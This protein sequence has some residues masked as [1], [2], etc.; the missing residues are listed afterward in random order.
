M[1]TTFHAS[2]LTN[3]KYAGWLKSMETSP[4][5]AFCKPFISS[6]NMDIDAINKHATL[7]KHIQWLQSSSIK[8]ETQSTMLDFLSSSKTVKVQRKPVDL[9]AVI[10][11]LARMI[12]IRKHQNLKLLILKG[13][14]LYL[15]QL[16][17]RWP[18]KC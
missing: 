2:W 16:M 6:T 8:S 7:Q 15:H 4:H 18:K 10:F 9:S 5:E 3:P 13:I 12:A 11:H 17:T 14:L 1:T